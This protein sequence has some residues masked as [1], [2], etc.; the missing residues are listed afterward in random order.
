VNILSSLL[1]YHQPGISNN[2]HFH[3]T[4]QFQWLLLPLPPKSSPSNPSSPTL[5]LTPRRPL[6][7]QHQSLMTTP[8]QKV[9]RTLTTRYTT[10]IPHHPSQIPQ[11][12]SSAQHAGLNS[13][14]QTPHFSAIAESVTI[15]ANSFRQPAKPSQPSQNSAPPRRNTPTNANHFPKTTASLV[16]GQNRNSGLANER[17]SLKQSWGMCYGTVSR[18]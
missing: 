8:P 6:P 15:P 4:H 14:P 17:F 3:P 16:S 13:I 11:P 12:F 2:H 7:L 9:C 18:I 1:T 5:I 10:P